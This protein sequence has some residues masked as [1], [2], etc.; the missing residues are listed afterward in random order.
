MAFIKVTAEELTSTASQL[1][2]TASQIE[3]ESSQAMGRVQSLVG[4]GWQGGASS[5]FES[6]FAEWQRGAEQLQTALATI[7]GQLTQAATKYDETESSNQAL[8][9]R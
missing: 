3:A 5:A 9:G 1:N 6:A 7:S 2:S 8:F 4:A